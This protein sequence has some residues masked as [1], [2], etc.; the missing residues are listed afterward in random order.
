MYVV[1]GATSRCD[2]S[3]LSL[4]VNKTK[5][6]A[7]SSLHSASMATPCSQRGAP[8]PL[9]CMTDDLRRYTDTTPSCQKGHT[10]VRSS[11]DRW[12]AHACQ[13]L[14]SLLSTW[15]RWAVSSQSPPVHRGTVVLSML[16]QSATQLSRGRLGLLHSGQWICS[17][18]CSARFLKKQLLK[19]IRPL[20]FPLFSTLNLCTFTQIDKIVHKIRFRVRNNV[21][22]F[23]CALFFCIVWT[24]I[25]LSLKHFLRLE[26]RHN[27]RVFVKY[28]YKVTLTPFM[29]LH[30]P[31]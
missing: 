14:S 7:Q 20:I 16:W 28:H 10:N 6:S 13:F 18:Y 12:R 24:T 9:G 17:I 21:I 27:L 2:N 22:V 5:G 26:Q 30:Y 11:Y 15:R 4:N 8:G 19:A 31:S 23:V 3:N 25:N 1:G 29:R